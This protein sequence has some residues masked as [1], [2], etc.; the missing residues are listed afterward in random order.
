MAKPYA[1][2][3]EHLSEM[4]RHS[5]YYY[6]VDR[7]AQSA[8]DHLDKSVNHHVFGDYRTAHAALLVAANHFS[9]HLTA[10]NHPDAAQLSGV[11]QLLGNTYKHAYEL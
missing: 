5:G 9:A 8:V 7:H 3:H 1:D 11:A 4:I 2:E 10:V 6:G